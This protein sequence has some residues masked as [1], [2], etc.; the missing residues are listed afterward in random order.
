MSGK[1]VRN[2]DGEPIRTRCSNCR[3]RVADCVK[4]T[5]EGSAGAH[6]LGFFCQTPECWHFVDLSITPTWRHI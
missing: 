6:V 3:G 4:V 5:E 2:V 1:D